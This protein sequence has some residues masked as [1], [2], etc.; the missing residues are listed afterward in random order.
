MSLCIFQSC[1][2][3]VVN[4][5]EGWWSI[6]TLYYKEY[7][8]KMCLYSNA[9]TFEKQRIDLPITEDRCEGL[10]IYDKNGTWTIQRSD[11]IPLLLRIETSNDI[12]AGTHKIVFRKDE[13]DKLLKVE[14][15]SKDLYLVARKGIYNYDRHI[16]VIDNLI[17][18]SHTPHPR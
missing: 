6:D 7:D 17:Q 15:S 11:S 2:D 5:M 4:T 1:T 12:F 9:I 16:D 10:S 8:S 18:I 14:I 3:I 13:Q